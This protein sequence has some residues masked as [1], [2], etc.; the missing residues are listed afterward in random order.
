MYKRKRKRERERAEE[1]DKRF[2][3]YCTGRVWILRLFFGWGGKV[4]CFLKGEKEKENVSS[5]D[6]FDLP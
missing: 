3:L 5:S 4:G 1:N 2:V 6:S